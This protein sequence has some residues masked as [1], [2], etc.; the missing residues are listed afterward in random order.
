MLRR[1]LATALWLGLAVPLGLNAFGPH[2]HI[3]TP[4]ISITLPRIPIPIPSP[5]QTMKS[6]ANDA[7]HVAQE[8]IKVANTG[9]QSAANAAKA[10]VT[11]IASA[12]SDITEAAQDI[13][14]TAANAGN[15]AAQGAA[16]ISQQTLQ[17]T[18]SAIQTTA[19]TA[20]HEASTIAERTGDL[21]R[22]AS[23]GAALA[24]KDVTKGLVNAAQTAGQDAAHLGLDAAHIAL[25]LAQQEGKARTTEL[26]A[27]LATAGDAV[28]DL[29]EGRFGHAAQDLSDTV[30]SALAAASQADESG[31]Q[32]K[33][34][35]SESIDMEHAQLETIQDVRLGQ[36]GRAAE[37]MGRSCTSAGQ[38][39]KP[40][41][42]ETGAVLIQAG[43]SIQEEAPFAEQL[44]KDVKK[45]DVYSAVHDTGDQYIDPAKTALQNGKAALDD[46][47]KGKFGEA[48]IE[49]T[50]AVALVTTGRGE[51]QNTD[52]AVLAAEAALDSAR[53]AL[54]AGKQGN[55]GTAAEHAGDALSSAG[56][57]IS[58]V[59]EQDGKELSEDGAEIHE[60]AVHGSE[61]VAASK[62][63]GE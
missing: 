54:N 43:T 2:I 48:T 7:T 29:R 52:E 21:A 37:A 27:A 6:V 46:A 59:D 13:A 28:A 12:G 31:A 55:Y 53:S 3:P 18:G 33:E 44:T 14:K 19:N 34:E 9:I 40:I 56:K 24:G 38:L 51:N 11:P 25:A 50:T 60:Y 15:D 22:S 16:S 62:A 10:G 8:S 45:G 41:D 35:F 5:A 63:T 32:V 30:S 58:A 42:P 47:Q 57:A 17:A 1:R 49:A 26:R 61:A 4:H 39:V 23:S 36:Y 20:A